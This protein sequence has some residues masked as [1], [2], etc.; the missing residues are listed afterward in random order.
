MGRKIVVTFDDHDYEQIELL[1]KLSR[2]KLA[3]Q[4][5]RMCRA[6]LDRTGWADHKAGAR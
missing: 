2:I 4:V 1:A 5:R 3:E 6:Q